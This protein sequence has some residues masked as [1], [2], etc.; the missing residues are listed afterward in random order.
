MFAVRA[1]KHTTENSAYR[2][3]FLFLGSF[4]KLRKTAIEFVM[5]VRLSV[6]PSTRNVP[7]PTSGIFMEFDI[8]VFLEILLTPFKFN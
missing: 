4:A 7:D 8:W 5:F 2:G 6:C 1:S 3:N